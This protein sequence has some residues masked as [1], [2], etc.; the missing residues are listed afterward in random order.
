MISVSGCSDS[1]GI[2]FSSKLNNIFAIPLHMFWEFFNIF[3]TRNEFIIEDIMQLYLY[4]DISNSVGLLN[5][6]I[7]SISRVHAGI[8]WKLL[9]MAQ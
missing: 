7:L 6:A 8:G 4:H 2:V 9:V 3:I 1:T 5:D